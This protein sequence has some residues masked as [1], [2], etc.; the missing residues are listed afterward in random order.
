MFEESDE[1]WYGF[2]IKEGRFEGAGD[3]NKLN[4]LIE[5]FMEM[6]S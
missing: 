5:I 3:P 4:K 2:R 6:V 1:N